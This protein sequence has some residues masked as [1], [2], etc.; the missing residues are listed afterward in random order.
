MEPR[1]ASLFWKRALAGV[2]MPMREPVNNVEIVV[3]Y[4]PDNVVYHVCEVEE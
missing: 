4:L 1:S 2:L 3:P